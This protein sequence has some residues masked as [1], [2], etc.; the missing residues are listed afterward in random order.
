MSVVNVVHSQSG[1]RLLIKVK[2]CVRLHLV[3]TDFYKN[4][5]S[6]L[7]IPP[8]SWIRLQKNNLQSQTARLGTTTH[9][10]NKTNGTVGALVECSTAALRVPG[11]VPSRNKHLYDLHLVV[12]GLAVCVFEF[13]YL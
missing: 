1:Q 7:G 11:S 5:R 10:Q 6:S 8:V 3:T 4:L 12:P 2:H 9:V 13:K